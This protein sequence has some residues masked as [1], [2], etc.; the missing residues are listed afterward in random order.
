VAAGGAFVGVGA[1]AARGSGFVAVGKAGTV[2]RRMPREELRG[3]AREP[4]LGPLVA[5]ALDGWV[6]S[7][8]ERLVKGVSPR[9]VPDLALPPGVAGPVAPGQR[10]SA[11][12]GVVWL[13]AGEAPLLFV[14]LSTVE[15]AA[16]GVFFPLTAQ[17]WLEPEGGAGEAVPVSTCA[18]AD[19][20]GTPAIWEGV[21]RFHEAVCECEFLNKRLLAVDEYE[22]LESKAR[23]SEA[24]REAAFDAIGAVL[25]GRPAEGPV[26]TGAGQLEPVLTAARL[27]AESL[28]LA[29]RPPAEAPGERTFHE[30]VAAI[31][32]ASRFR[33]RQVALRGEW[34]RADAGPLLGCDAEG[35]PVALLPRST[36]SYTC[37]FVVTGQKRKV[38]ADVA[39]ALVPFA[40]AFYRALPAGA[41]GITDLVRFGTRG[42]FRDRASVIVLGVLTG[43]LGAAV[44]FLIGQIVDRAI[45]QAEK[46]VLLQLALGMAAVTMCA[47]LLQLARSVALV[48]LET[49]MDHALQAALWDRLL[50]LPSSFFR[51]YGAGDLAERAG[52]INA[53]RGVLSRSAA[54]ASLGALSGLAYVALMFGLSPALAL[55]ALGVTFVL[56]TF[57]TVG[58]LLLLRAQRAQ[59]DLHG[60]I[61][62]LVLQLIAG[63]AKV[64]VSGAENHAFRVWAQRFSE[65]KRVS[66]RVGRLGATLATVGAGFQVLAPLAIFAAI[67]ELQSGTTAS[68]LST[69]QFV[70][71]YSAFVSFAG[72]VQGLSAA[73]LDLLAVVPFYQ[74]LQ[75]I[76]RTL[77]ETDE[78][79]AYPGRLTGEINVSRVNFRYGPD[80]PLVLQDVSFTVKP[81][82][83]VAFVGP[84]GCGKSTLLRL[85]LGFEKPV[86]G[87]VYYDGLDLAH[88]D[89]RAVRQQ[90]GVVL[91]ESRV[92][93]TD[94]FR[95]IVGNSSRTAEEAW[96]AAE[97]AG[98]ADDIRQ[99]PMQLHTVVSEGGG[100]FSGG[101]RQRLLIARALVNKPR[102]LYLDE[103]TS[104]LD[105]RAQA[106]VTRSMAQLDATRVVVAHRLSTV[107]DADRILFLEG[108]QIR[109]EGTYRELMEKGGLFAEFARR[110]MA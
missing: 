79:K 5:A 7:V 104:A 8:G 100:T 22:R 2:A 18:T 53:I 107:M 80:T 42:L 60:E 32:A 52:G 94:I 27:V 77:P 99:M 88:L 67:H 83:F 25:G 21:D 105:N 89:V 14:G 16:P 82:E 101:Q 57:S 74:R 97:M 81:G 95:N 29:V 34:W 103:A 38:N 35:A 19:L 30:H 39:Q 6:Q 11:E 24:A 41:L 98:L 17:T 61:S 72:S 96:E 33:V 93:P 65:Q 87:A 43:A 56:V 106:V 70:A 49:R 75:P 71:F 44:P 13:E 84:S 15:T 45:P 69:G 73:S 76:L 66:F 3:L 58:S 1:G 4:E 51:Q 31:A 102:L 54:S 9:P 55:V 62:G 59:A 63:V 50:E 92:L 110:Q 85:L 46:G 10:V 12:K 86:S 90:L 37:A 64:R 48:R 47:A 40:F 109:E 26:A 28:G 68:S 108:G 78:T 36:R 91:Q 20:L 23:E